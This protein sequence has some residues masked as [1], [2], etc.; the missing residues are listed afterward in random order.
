MC[1]EKQLTSLKFWW[2]LREESIGAFA[3]IGGPAAGRDCAA[4]VLHLRLKA[5]L[6]AERQQLLG[7]PEGACRSLAPEQKEGPFPVSEPD[8]GVCYVM[9]CRIVGD[10]GPEAAG[11]AD[12]AEK[13][14]QPALKRMI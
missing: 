9:L 5:T 8:R 1:D 11:S 12:G 7:P 4:F 13:I 6:C 14:R 10:Q 3:K 2:P